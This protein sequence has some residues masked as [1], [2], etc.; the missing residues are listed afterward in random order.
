MAVCC[1]L[2]MRTLILHLWMRYSMERSFETAGFQTE[3]SVREPYFTLKLLLHRP[4][5]RVS[6]DIRFVGIPVEINFDFQRNF[7]SKLS[8]VIGIS[9]SISTVGI[10]IPI[11]NQHRKRL[12]SMKNTL[13]FR[14]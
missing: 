13:K 10:E 14:H 6:T 7:W 8:K 11:S 2:D 5:T 3:K 1:Q 4:I 9:I 12:I